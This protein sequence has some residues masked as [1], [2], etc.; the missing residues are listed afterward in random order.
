MYANNLQKIDRHIDLKN[1]QGASKSHKRWPVVSN[2][3]KV[4]P[5]PTRVPPPPRN[6]GQATLFNKN[7]NIRL[8]WVKKRRSKEPIP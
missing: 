7:C 1:V 5:W 8:I 4:V 6:V 2:L 3:L